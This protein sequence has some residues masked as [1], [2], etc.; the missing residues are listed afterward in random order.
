MGCDNEQKISIATFILVSLSL[1][2]PPVSYKI[3]ALG[4]IPMETELTYF[5]KKYLGYFSE[6]G[7]MRHGFC[8]PSL[9][10]QDDNKSG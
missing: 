3:L 8:E 5:L 2:L 4:T 10:P 7:F 9:S 6:N 1:S